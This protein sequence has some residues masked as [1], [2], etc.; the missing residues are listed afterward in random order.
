MKSVAIILLAIFLVQ[1][2]L[3]AQN[4]EKKFE[5]LPH[6]AGF[7]YNIF[8]DEMLIEGFLKRDIYAVRYGYRFH[9]N[10]VVGGE[11]SGYVAKGEMIDGSANI[12]GAFIRYDFICSKGFVP[13]IEAQGFYSNSKWSHTFNGKIYEYGAS[14]FSSYAAPGFSLFLWKNRLSLDLYYKFTPSKDF[15][16][17]NGKHSV[18]SYKLNFY[19]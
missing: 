15:R 19:F 5:F 1:S 14:G 6:Q 9:K 12:F 16:F 17:V 3:F 18:F 8:I 7:Q 4:E 13:F 11:Y 2:K 10:F